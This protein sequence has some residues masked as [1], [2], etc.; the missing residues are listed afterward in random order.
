MNQFHC[1][2]QHIKT[3]DTYPDLTYWATGCGEEFGIVGDLED[4]A[5]KYCPAC[6]LELREE[7]A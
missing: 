3:P 4:N 6:G 5:W 7:S 2:W 1:G